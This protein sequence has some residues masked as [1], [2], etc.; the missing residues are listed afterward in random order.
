MAT[1]V[2]L[3]GFGRIGRNILRTAWN[4]ADVE[5]VHINDLTSDEMLAYLL[6]NDSVHGAWDHDVEAVE[7][8]IR[9]DDTVIKTTATPDPRELPWGASSVDVVMECTGVF[10]SRDRASYHLEAGARKVIISA[11]AGDPDLT[12]CMGVNDEQIREEHRIISNASCTT[13]CLS[14]VAKVLHAN[15]GIE[16]GMMTTVHSYT[17]DQRLLDAPH[18]DFRR[19]R[20][21]A[22]NMVPTTTGA[23]KAVGLV[24]PELDGKLNGMA[25]RV[26]TPNVS[27]VDLVFRSDKPMTAEA[28]NEALTLA[29]NGPMVGVLQVSHAPMVSTDLIGNPHSSIVDALSTQTSGERMAKV[30]SWYDNEW[31]FSNRMVQLAKRIG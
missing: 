10:R 30:L 19:S 18:K 31:G 4:D 13:N 15:F 9:I 26:P 11:P 21:A 2:A 17:M 28:I 24:L 27:L 23:A 1:R 5:F 16:S 7:G 25:I 12:V 29:A 22:L 6:K 14:P 20:S 3:N 8:G